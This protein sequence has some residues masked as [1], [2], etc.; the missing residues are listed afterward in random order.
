MR[1]VRQDGLE[2]L[3]G[4]DASPGILT[5]FTRRVTPSTWVRGCASFAFASGVF[6]DLRGLDLDAARAQP[7]PS[8][9]WSE[10]LLLGEGSEGGFHPP[11]RVGKREARVPFASGDVDRR[12]A[13][14]KTPP[15]DCFS[16]A[17]SRSGGRRHE[18]GSCFFAR[19]DG[20]AQSVFALNRVAQFTSRATEPRRDMHTPQL[21]RPSHDETVYH[22]CS[23]PNTCRSRLQRPYLRFARGVGVLRR[24]CRAKRRTGLRRRFGSARAAPA[25]AARTPHRKARTPRTASANVRVFGSP[26]SSSLRAWNPRGRRRSRIRFGNSRRPDASRGGRPASRRPG[27]RGRK[28]RGRSANRRPAADRD[29]R[30]GQGHH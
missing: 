5:Y 17:T 27:T 12:S 7:R 30:A 6:G 2:L 9:P 16:V 24:V 15:T 3:E 13:T 28:R 8:P 22:G 25:R 19:K 18:C 1:V 21:H 23:K 26:R 20:F 11:S 4:K 10:F 29:G 14:Q